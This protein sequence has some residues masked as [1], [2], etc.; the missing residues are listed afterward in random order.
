MPH[1]VLISLLLQPVIPLKVLISVVRR[2]C[3]VFSSGLDSISH[4]GSYTG[5][6]YSCFAM[7]SGEAFNVCGDP[8]F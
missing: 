4:D 7:I 1:C 6:V 5:F 8:V 2:S 3:G